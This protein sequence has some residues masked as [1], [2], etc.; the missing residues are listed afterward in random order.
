[1][2][3]CLGTIMQINKEIF[4]NEGGTLKIRYYTVLVLANL[5]MLAVV[6][7]AHYGEG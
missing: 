4:T 1:L 3:Q 2:I 5:L 6:A 7:Y